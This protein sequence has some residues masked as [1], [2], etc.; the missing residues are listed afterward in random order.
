MRAVACFTLLG[1]LAIVTATAGAQDPWLVFKSGHYSVFYQTAFEKDLAFARTWADRAEVLMKDK[2]GVVPEHY[3]MAIYLHP[4]PTSVANVDNARNHCCTTAADGLKTGMID[5]LA[6]SAA[7]WKDVHAI[8][9]LGMPKNDESYH[10]KVL[11]S[12]YI[13]IGHWEAQD[14]R[15]AG[16][17]Q[18]YK[19]P[20]WFVQGLQE[21]DAI[22][23]TTPTNRDVTAKH[24][25][26]W[27][28]ENRGVVVCCADGLRIADA[29]N[30]GAAFMTFLAAQFGEPI[31]AAL[32]RDGSSTF[33]AALTN[34]TKP[35]SR[36]QLFDAFT[37][38]IRR[39]KTG[40]V[41]GGGPPNWRRP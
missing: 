14:A 28:A 19:A 15:P 26:A 25:L 21:Y 2:Y 13:P 17:W 16:G 30:G 35:M 9:S 20:N 34:V 12:E 22:F 7:A 6:P 5:L 31:H 3:R 29:Y 1:C 11:M 18:Y 27:A 23:H 32:L 41:S 10:A 4:A 38:W 8:S 36:E 40:E 37:E 33:D 24:L 39:T